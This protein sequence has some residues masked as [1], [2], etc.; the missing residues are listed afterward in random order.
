MNHPITRITANAAAEGLWEENIQYTISSMSSYINPNESKNDLLNAGI[1]DAFSKVLRNFNTL[2]DLSDQKR[3]ESVA[4]GSM[5]GAGM[6]GGTSLPGVSTLNE[7]MGGDGGAFRAYKRDKDRAAELA[8]WNNST[9]IKDATSFDGFKRKPSKSIKL[10]KEDGKSWINDGLKVQ[11]INDDTFKQLAEKYELDAE[12]GGEKEILG[13]LILKNGAPQWDE[14]KVKQAVLDTKHREALLDLE[15]ALSQYPEKNKIAR[16]LVRKNML[17]KSAMD[18]FKDGLGQF[19]FDKLEALKN[20]SEEELIALGL[21]PNNKEADIE[22]AIQYATQLE[23]LYNAVSEATV[24]DTSSVEDMLM[25]KMRTGFM[26]DRGQMIMAIDAA[27]RTNREDINATL[28]SIDWSDEDQE[29]VNELMSLSNRLMSA[30]LK[31]YNDNSDTAFTKEL[32]K[33]NN[34]LDALMQKAA[35]NAESTTTNAVLGELERKQFI[36]EQL[37]QSR[38]NLKSDYDKVSDPRAESWKSYIPIPGV[39]FKTKGFQ[40]FKNNYQELFDKYSDVRMEGLT[41]TDTTTLKTYKQ[42]EKEQ[43]NKLKLKVKLDYLTA[44][45]VSNAWRLQVSE[46]AH[47]VSVISAILKEGGLISQEDRAELDNYISSYID[48]LTDY[49]N[50][51]AT[52]LQNLDNLL[53]NPE[54][55]EEEIQEARNSVQEWK[56]YVISYQQIAEENSD[57]VDVMMI[58]NLAKAYQDAIERSDRIFN[59][60]TATEEDVKFTL[61]DS[62]TTQGKLA[63]KRVEENEEYD[64]VP[65]VEKA[66]TQVKNLV[67]LFEERDDLDQPRKERYVTE[68]KSLIAELEEVLNEVKKRKANRKLKETK[69]LRNRVKHTLKFLGITFEEDGSIYFGTSPVYDKIKAIVGDEFIIA[70]EAAISKDIQDQVADEEVAIPVPNEAY[71]YTLMHQLGDQYQSTIQETV[72]GAYSDLLFFIDRSKMSTKA[73]D[74][75]KDKLP[76][77]KTNSI[78]VISYLFRFLGTNRYQ[79]NGETKLAFDSYPESVIYQYMKDLDLFKALS[80][81]EN[82]VGRDEANAKGGSRLTKQEVE[83]VLNILSTFYI[84][85]QLSLMSEIDM[86]NLLK[87]ERSKAVEAKQGFDAGN[88]ADFVPSITQRITLYQT[89]RSIFKADPSVPMSNVT[90][91]KGPAGAGKSLVVGKWI[92]KIMNLDSSNVLTAGHNVHSAANI[93]NSVDTGYP[94]LTAKELLKQ[95]EEGA[96]D[97]NV[98]LVIIDEAPA[99]I[100]G[101]LVKLY[102]AIGEYSKDNP[103]VHFVLMG[104][105]N[106]IVNTNVVSKTTPP[107]DQVFDSS[108]PNLVNVAVVPPLTVRYRT[109]NPAILDVQDAFMDNVEAVTGL[110]GVT[111]VNPEDITTENLRA[112]GSYVERS[113]ANLL[114]ILY[115]QIRNAPSEGMTRAVIVGTEEAAQKYKD[116]ISTAIGEEALTTKVEVLTVIQAQGRTFGEV[117]VDLSDLSHADSFKF[118]QFMYTA[119]S[120]AS[121]FLYVANIENVENF[122]DPSI[123]DIVESNK[124]QVADLYDSHMQQVNSELEVYTNL[125]ELLKP[126]AEPNTKEETEEEEREEQAE[127]EEIANKNKNSKQ[128]T[129]EDSQEESQEDTEKSQEDIEEDTEDYVETNEEKKSTEQEE[130]EKRKAQRQEILNNGLE[131]DFFRILEPSQNSFFFS[132]EDDVAYEGLRDKLEEGFVSAKLIKMADEITGDYKYAIV[133]P[134][135][136][137]QVE[138]VG[139]LTKGEAKKL[140]IPSKLKGEVFGDY[141]GG[142]RYSVSGISSFLDVQIHPLSSKMN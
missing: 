93:A 105:P 110:R 97:E 36:Q 37:D 107:L 4:L 30:R 54:A 42:Y 21:D 77:I 35:L 64:D 128:N 79:E 24:A 9:S 125:E 28:Q 58:P 18:H 48:E 52:A 101:D 72:D 71:L 106:Q 120:R 111:N 103:E 43:L 65:A 113:N 138:V 39:K 8:D 140:G 86:Q 139:A 17:A 95:L 133:I 82:E 66:I 100:E 46:G 74:A 121:D 61:A 1:G 68:L 89:I 118:N 14:V 119:T 41:L 12:K 109:D 122:K 80:D 85:E 130:T 20:A 70:W 135:E 5:I 123:G 10:Y 59:R 32:N 13:D 45:N 34:K 124:A 88:K 141:L 25:Q 115:N 75:V 23:D 60:L 56:D 92:P 90:I 126:K 78:N 69:I 98:N 15:D 2:M 3:L 116:A 73:K 53:H 11:E 57:A 112:I 29:T 108:F 49:A 76:G 55:T 47:P 27:A 6:A 136:K 129:P 19:Y 84:S 104:D 33:F 87:R 134:L 81:I 38:K 26:L 22:E 94:P 114:T 137:G 7:R 67:R 132:E 91:I 127:E 31:F 99:I 51:Y 44:K 117:Y 50:E 142:N 16:Q 62:F 63:I 96:I 102:R 83:E 131:E 40:Y